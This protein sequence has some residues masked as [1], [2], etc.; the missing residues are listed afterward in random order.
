M[1]WM[2]RTRQGMGDSAQQ[3]SDT[4]IARSHHLVVEELGDELLVY[5]LRQ[6][7]AHSLGAS[8]ARVWRACDGETSVDSLASKAGV[9]ADT[10]ARALTELSKCELLDGGAAQPTNGYTRRDA[11]VKVAKMG[12]ALAAV[13]LI[14][15]VAAP[16]AAMAVTVTEEFCQALTVQGHGC[17]ECHKIGCCCCEPPGTTGSSVTKPCHA[18]CITHPDCNIGVQPNCNGP[19]ANCKL[20]GG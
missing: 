2:N 15:S 7:R 18:D 4:P 1:G 12:A 20:K 16:A 14:V 5:D 10:V 6:N 3:A 17:G 19:T 8:A 13:P 11:G 9:D